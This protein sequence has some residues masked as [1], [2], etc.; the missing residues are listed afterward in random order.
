M[1]RGLRIIRGFVETPS[2]DGLTF[3]LAPSA[4]A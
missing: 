3:I 2:V 4:L 1:P